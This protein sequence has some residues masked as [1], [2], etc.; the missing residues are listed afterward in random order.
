MSQANS[1]IFGIVDCPIFELSKKIISIDPL[2]WPW[3]NISYCLFS[4][5]EIANHSNV[6]VINLSTKGEGAKNPVNVVMDAPLRR[7]QKRPLATR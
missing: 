3:N 2:S 5:C 6:Y 4:I 7:P 1:Q